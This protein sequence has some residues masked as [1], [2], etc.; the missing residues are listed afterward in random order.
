VSQFPFPPP[1]KVIPFST[2]DGKQKQVAHIG[3]VWDLLAGAGLGLVRQPGE[4]DRL[5]LGNEMPIE[6]ELLITLR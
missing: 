4:H 2:R 5:F 6:N 3:T 1:V